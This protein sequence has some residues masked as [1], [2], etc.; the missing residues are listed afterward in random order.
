M[1]GQ[2]SG[3]L[4]VLAVALALLG[5]CNGGD[6]DTIVQGGPNYPGQYPG[7]KVGDSNLALDGKALSQNDE[8]MAGGPRVF[9]SSRANQAI[10]LYQTIDNGG[11]GVFTLWASY[12]NGLSVTPPVEII[13][14]SAQGKQGNFFAPIEVDAAI[15]MFYHPSGVVGNSN[16]TRDGDAVILFSRYDTDDSSP[17]DSNDSNRRL[18]F[19]YFDRSLAA[20]P[21]QGYG[22]GTFDLSDNWRP[23]YAD[24]VDSDD[25]ENFSTNDPDNKMP[26]S[27]EVFGVVSDGLHGEGAFVNGFNMYNQTDFR[28][29]FVATW[30]QWD[31]VNASAATD[32]VDSHAWWSRFDMTSNPPGFSTPQRIAT[33]S[34]SPENAGGSFV[35]PE[36]IVAPAFMTAN[37]NALVFMVQE[38]PDFDVVVEY[39][40]FTGDSSNG[41]TG[42]AFLPDAVEASPTNDPTDFNQG[43]LTELPIMYGPDH[44][45]TNVVIFLG[46]NS[47]L[48]GDSD[49]D[50]FIARF[51]NTAASAGTAFGAS[52]RT[53]VDLTPTTPPNQRDVQ[54]W[55]TRISRDNDYILAVFVQTDL[56]GWPEIKARR[57]VTDEIG[58]PPPPGSVSNSLGTVLDVS[59]TSVDY[60]ADAFVLQRELGSSFIPPTEGVGVT[61]V[62]R[63]A[64]QS[65][66]DRMYIVYEHYDDFTP[67]PQWDEIFVVQFQNQAAPSPGTTSSPASLDTFENF[68]MT[69]QGQ[70]EDATA[71]MDDGDG[72]VVTYYLQDVNYDPLNPWIMD[73]RLRARDYNGVT[74]S[75]A[76]DLNSS[77]LHVVQGEVTAM[78]AGTEDPDGSIHLIFFDED[79]YATTGGNPASSIA[80]RFRRFDKLDGSTSFTINRF[81][82]IHTIDTRQSVDAMAFA[83]TSA[84][85]TGNVAIYMEQG[86]HIFYNEYTAS[87]DMWK[88]AASYIVDNDSAVDANNPMVT[89]FRPYLPPDLMLSGE[90]AGALVFWTRFDPVDGDDRLFLRIH[91]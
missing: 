45:L 5:G 85:G 15:A 4:W 73:W 21:S 27:V 40:H 3:V 16:A 43:Q 60:F 36:T 23:G 35:E 46:F 25:G 87:T 49:N 37:E 72:G 91:N 30:I 61:G 12:F 10:I 70:I 75:G 51:D 28:H 68:T 78:T 52:D 32:T 26:D 50:L 66:N 55:D 65:D 13:T 9:Y 6:G 83:G 24:T 63:S 58:G 41:F 39:T 84:G 54:D 64:I 2:S 79:R 8:N 57:F 74:M 81:G 42:G 18:W 14:I 38:V 89:G 31:E 7:N 80:A 1:R 71:T 88:D 29:Y 77:G 53:Q 59:D 11:T 48:P 67:P 56:I 17:T 34:S 33:D 20:Q 90:T 22:F 19:C 47:N 76:L 69:F 82:M 86:G 44:N 62:R